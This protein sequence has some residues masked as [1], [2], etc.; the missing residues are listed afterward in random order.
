MINFRS[1]VNVIKNS[2]VCDQNIS[3]KFYTLRS[4]ITFIT[5]AK[6]LNMFCYREWQDINKFFSLPDQNGCLDEITSS[7]RNFRKFN[8]PL[9]LI[10]IGRWACIAN[11]T[12]R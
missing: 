7:C 3:F 10:I 5:M 6:K 1:D 2:K 9:I 4:F 12:K 11:Y 8:N